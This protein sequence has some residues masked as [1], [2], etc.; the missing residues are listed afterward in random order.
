MAINF[1][2]E[3]KFTLKQSAQIKR[4]IKAVI[5]KEKC[6]PGNI[7]Y[8]FVDDEALLKINLD[9]L[10]HN[11]YTDIITFDY[12]EEG[13]VSGDI[14]ISVERV[15]ENAL[16]FKVDAEEELRRVMI[17]GVLHLCGYKDK[18]KGDAALM[19]K[20]ENASLKLLNKLKDI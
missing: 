17:H 10:N 9:Y 5:E 4:W 6:L 14:Y 20:K 1:H 7:N 12:T 16:K 8:I 15:R 2:K 18:T 11:T 3:T 19:R 13:T